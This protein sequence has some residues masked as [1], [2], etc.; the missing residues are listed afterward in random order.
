MKITKITPLVVAAPPNRN[1]IFVK[2]E[3]DQPG[4]Y[5]WGEA[6][7]E[8][9]TRGVVGCIEDF[10]HIVVGHDPRDVTQLVELLSKVAF[11]PLGVYGLTA[12]SAIEQACWDIKGKDL[13]VPVWQLLGGKVRDRIRVYTHLG[14]GR[15]KVNRAT[16]DID[17]FVESAADLREM[18][19]NAVKITPVP[20]M[21]FDA[22][23]RHVRH[24]EKLI[25]G[26]REA[27]GPDVDLLLDFHG[28]PASIAAALA[29]I[30]VVSPF[31]PMF[32]EEPIQPG[33]PAAM[34]IVAD[35]AGCP[36]ATGERLL[37]PKEFETL[38]TMKAVTYIQPDLCHCGGLTIGRQIA[39]IAAA[40]HIGVCPHNPMGPIAGVVGL[41]FAVATPNF[42]I[43]EESSGSVPWYDDVVSTPITRVD[44]Y[45]QLPMK[46]GLGVE[47]NEDVARKH[48]FVQEV[49][50][51]KAAVLA[52]DGSRANW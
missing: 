34:H 9:K 7:L 18:G 11:W 8:W 33:D 32:V 15:T 35:R 42:V 50:S 51:S 37:T 40:N 46:P 28:R 5:G 14:T 36:I 39:N 19:Y 30:D 4:L 21:G 27:L 10:E 22:E 47:I 17:A 26:I 44:G 23:P 16:L 12:M 49:I 25:Q 41:H 6:T 29:Y 3:T 52:R 1:W 20:Y 43:L 24:T 2:V 38:C 31:K 13:G 48:P 45:W